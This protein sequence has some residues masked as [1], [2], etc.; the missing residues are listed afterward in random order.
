VDVRRAKLEIA[1]VI[2]TGAVFL[3]FENV[4]HW[5]LQFLVPCTLLWTGYLAWRL[6]HDRSQAREWGLRRDTLA[7]A[8]LECL[9]IAVAMAAVLLSYRLARGWRPLPLSILVLFALYPVWGFIQQFVVQALVAGNLER[10]GAPR[11]AVVAV[12]AALYGLA[13]LPDLPLVG[14]CAAAGV[15]WTIVFLRTRN[16]VPLAIM[17]GWLGAIAYHWVL[18]RDPWREMFR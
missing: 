17:H 1:A 18:E 3:V 2:L 10:L 16:L 7:R 6:A 11:A 14:L 15:A 12:A 13:H 8:T 4:L 9:V 5:K